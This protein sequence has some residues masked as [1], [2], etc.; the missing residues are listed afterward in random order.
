MKKIIVYLLAFLFSVNVFANSNPYLEL[1]SIFQKIDS[2]DFNQLVLKIEKI[3]PAACQIDEITISETEMDF[4][5]TFCQLELTATLKQVKKMLIHAKKMD[6][7]LKENKFDYKKL[8]KLISNI[9][10]DI[11]VEFALKY[12][13]YMTYVLANHGDM[14]KHIDNIQKLLNSV[15]K[16]SD[17][18]MRCRALLGLA[19]LRS[20]NDELAIS[21][22]K[23]SLD[24]FIKKGDKLNAFYSAH[25]L[26]A[27]YMKLKNKKMYKYYNDIAKK[28]ADKDF[29]LQQCELAFMNFIHLLEKDKFDENDKKIFEENREFII[30][31]STSD[32]QLFTVYAFSFIM[33]L[34]RDFQQEN[35]LEDLEKAF[36]YKDLMWGAEFPE[37]YKILDNMLK[38]EL[39]LAYLAETKQFGK[40]NYWNEKFKSYGQKNLEKISVPKLQP[41]CDSIAKYQRAKEIL[42]SEEAK[43]YKE[44]DKKL[45]Q[46]ATK[47]KRE[48]E[49]QFELAKRQLSD[50]ESEIFNEL[51]SNDYII[52]PNSLNQLSAVLPDKMACVQYIPV[53]DKIFAHIVIKNAPPFLHQID[54]KDKNLTADKFNTKLFKIKTVLENNT[55]EQ[56]IKKEMN[57]LYKLI[58]ADIEPELNKLNIEKILVN[59]SGMLRSIPFA[60]LFDGNKYLLEKYQITNITGMD[61]IRLARSSAARTVKNTKIAVFAD[62]DGS[63]ASARQEGRQVAKL[64]V[65]NQC[66][67]G[68]D[69][70][71]ENFESMLGDINFIHLA[72]H[73][74]IDTERPEQSYIKFA[75]DKKW[76]YSDMMGFNVKNVDS[77][78]LSACSTGVN[79]KNNGGEIESMAAKLL[80]KSPSGS[81]IASFWDIDD[82]AT[83]AF[84]MNYYKNILESIK[85]DNVLDKGKAFRKAQLNLLKNKST[86]SPFYWAAFVFYGDF[87]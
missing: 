59:S 45:I 86:S 10:M 60:A 85:S 8:S 27:V 78:V 16:N 29:M 64:F 63:L 69:A 33:K 44:R 7:L 14:I 65:D 67:I 28:Y 13:M 55:D 3:K 49:E 24:Y 38:P 20:Q 5:L 37:N 4:L 79:V 66:F 6:H 42:L 53:G 39:L 22:L 41:L 40:L 1:H 70:S 51:I 48:L 84:M 58:F 82:G 36:H 23:D 26:S 57:D 56:H 81:I 12:D 76:Y 32:I 80:Q 25:N 17:K 15:E 35:M 47:I 50:K 21:P 31:N 62:P 75:D 34:T 73:A 30:K 61:M 2:L 54:L 74:V 18:Y 19:F 68:N 71:L 11:D 87:R 72:T 46:S 83:A 43:P 77:I 52:S 9:I